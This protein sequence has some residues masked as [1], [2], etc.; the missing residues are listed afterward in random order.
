M[1][2][3]SRSIMAFLFA[4][5]VFGGAWIFMIAAIWADAKR[6][7]DSQRLMEENE[8]VQNHG[9]TDQEFINR[10]KIPFRKEGGQYRIRMGDTCFLLPDENVASASRTIHYLNNHS[11]REILLEV[12]LNLS[13]QTIYPVAPY[14]EYRSGHIFAIMDYSDNIAEYSIPYNG[15][16]GLSIE[17]DTQANNGFRLLTQTQDMGRLYYRGTDKFECF[18]IPRDIPIGMSMCHIIFNYKGINIKF[19]TRLKNFDA[20]DKAKD[21]FVHFLDEHEAPCKTLTFPKPGDVK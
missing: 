21:S 13:S 10:S 7:A 6:S 14:G 20:F 11:E 16:W 5:L 15:L 9:I 3:P 8:L 18:T 1:T 17:S 12:A 4:C 2:P 19:G